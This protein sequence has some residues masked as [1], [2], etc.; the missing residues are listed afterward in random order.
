M[1]LVPTVDLPTGFCTSAAAYTV[2]SPLVDGLD[3]TSS[4]G[5]S[6]FCDGIAEVSYPLDDT[7][8]SSLV[9]S[10]SGACIQVVG[11]SYNMVLIRNCVLTLDVG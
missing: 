9:R 6:S 8:I 2:T 11:L 5:T 10:T 7:Q 1:Q 3:L 4:A